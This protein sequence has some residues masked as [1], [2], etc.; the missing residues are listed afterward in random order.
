MTKMTG[1]KLAFHPID[2]L[3]KLASSHDAGVVYEDVEFFRHGS[4]LFRG[5]MNGCIV[6]KVALNINDLDH[7]VDL[8]DLGDDRVHFCLVA[9][10]KENLG[11]VGIGDGLCYF[12]TD[13]ILAWTSNEDFSVKYQHV[14]WI[15]SDSR[16]R[17]RFPCCMAP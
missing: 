9:A 3:L 11:G 4:D 1:G 8:I 15:W 12:G 6:A 2:R 13:A 16:C 10:G 7:G 5:A 14:C 17:T